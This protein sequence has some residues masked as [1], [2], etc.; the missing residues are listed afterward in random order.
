MGK[1]SILYALSDSLKPMY[2][3]ELVHHHHNYKIEIGIVCSAP[4]VMCTACNSITFTQITMSSTTT[5]AVAK[6]AAIAA[7]LGLVAMSFASF[8]P[9]AKAATVDDL[10]AQIA[11]L[12]AQIAALQGGSSASMTFTMD[13]TIGSTGAEVTALQNWLIKGGYSI[14][15][16]ATGYF[17]TQTQ[18]ALA[19]YQAANGI[20]PAAGYFGPITRAK[21]NATGGTTTG[22]STS[23]GALQGGEADLSNFDLRGEESTGTEGESNVELATAKFDVDDADVSVQSIEV[24]FDAQNN[25]IE[26]KPWQFFDNLSVSMDGKELKSVSVD[27]KSDWDQHGSGSSATYSLKISGLNGIVREGDKAELTIA[28]D[29]ASSIDNS[30]QAQTFKINVTKDGIRARDAAGVDQYIGDDSDTATFGFDAEESGD[31]SV[32]ESDEDPDAA[33]LVANETKNSED[34]TVFAFDLRNKDDADAD[35]T[36]VTIH[37]ATSSTSDNT[38]LSNIIRRATLKVA[39]EEFDG[40]IN[41]DGTIVFNDMDDVTVGGNDTETF[42]LEIQ[43]AS[44]SGHY[45]ATGNN[46]KFSVDAANDDIV[47][48]GSDNGDDSS[49]TG[50]YSGAQHTIAL[51]GIV[52]E[53]VSTSATENNPTTGSSSTDRGVFSIKFN[54]TALEDDAFIPNAVGTTSSAVTG[55]GVIYDPYI[56]GATTTAFTGVT[57]TSL[58]STAQLSGGYFKVPQGTTKQFTLNVTNDPATGA[59]LGIGL[60]AIQFGS[61]TSAFAT[62]HAT[63]TIDSKNA[64][65]RTDSVNVTN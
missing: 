49:V 17:G 8:A 20:A 10:Q 11:A 26:T 59:Y 48:E 40:D 58:S 14:P 31:L 27:S 55:T 22:G 56:N 42:T 9:A 21:V 64:D 34:Y 29:I 37:V 46:L 53:A 38:P 7:G 39:G 43:L 23:T 61:S 63:S 41:S 3:R 32:R 60:N 54:V 1:R 4:L 15:A 28:A 19:K 62:Q 65:F 44:Q 2:R 12:M 57:T 6:I 25:G 45:A 35:V 30:D 13:L 47:A 24:N 52:V 50:S 36:D 51:T 16:G 5:N 33:I 18:A